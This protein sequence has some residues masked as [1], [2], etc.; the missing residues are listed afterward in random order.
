[1]WQK[2]KSAII[3]G[4][5]LCC[6]VFFGLG[7]CVGSSGKGYHGGVQRTG[8]Q[9]MENGNP[10]MRHGGRNQLDKPDNSNPQDSTGN[11]DQKQTAPDTNGGNQTAPDTNDGNQTTPGANEGTLSPSVYLFGETYVF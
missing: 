8:I 1:M 2:Y 11:E 4:V 5:V 10:G 3:T 9:S 6:I 7:Y